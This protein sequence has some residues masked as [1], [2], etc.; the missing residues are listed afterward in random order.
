[1]LT[2]FSFEFAI[3]TVAHIVNGKH[4]LSELMI[5]SRPAVLTTK[6]C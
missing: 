3:L 6:I 4:V 1:M 5:L 2:M